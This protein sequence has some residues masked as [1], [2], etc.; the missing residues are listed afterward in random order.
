MRGKIWIDLDVTTHI[1]TILLVPL[2]HLNA[3]KNMVSWQID[4]VYVYVNLVAKLLDLSLRF[5]M[6][7]KDWGKMFLRATICLM[8]K[9]SWRTFTQKIESTLGHTN[10]TLIPN[11]LILLSPSFWQ[12]GNVL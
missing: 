12:H 8:S 1:D 2:L 6:L 9:S 5:A 10:F 7:L 4:L 3:T 11:Y